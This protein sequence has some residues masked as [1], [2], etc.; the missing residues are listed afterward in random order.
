MDG[1]GNFVVV[2]NANDGS[3]DGVFATV[4]DRNGNITVSEFRVNDLITDRQAVVDVKMN[5]NGDFAIIWDNLTTTSVAGVYTKRYQLDGSALGTEVFVSD[6]G[7]KQY[8]MGI[9]MS[10]TG[11]FAI[12]MYRQI[13]QTDEIDV[14]GQRFD[15]QGNLLG[16]P[17]L[18]NSY[19]TGTQIGN[20]IAMDA[21]GNFVIS[22][23]SWNQD[24]EG[25]GIYAQRY[26]TDGSKLGGEFLVNTTTTNSQEFARVAMAGDG[27]FVITWEHNV[28]FVLPTL[29]PVIQAR[30]YN[31]NG[32]PLGA[33][34]RISATTDKLKSQP[35]V[36]ADVCGNFIIG[37]SSFD[38]SATNGVAIARR[39]LAENP[40]T[41]PCLINSQ[42][43]ANLSGDTYSWQYY[44]ITVP[45]G[46]SILDIQQWGPVTGDADLYVKYGALPTFTEWDY[47]P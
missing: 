11:L 31:T 33:E 46:Q 29:L 10:Q 4:Y 39:Y 7:D 42:T 28:E 16:V 18:V 41:G 47:R 27:S 14:W 45:A 22:W 44:K 5:R 25:W 40:S 12:T 21:V 3:D 32:V 23:E 6:G 19:L 43:V 24:G 36:G 17:F 30:Q 8:A 35:T 37:W 20:D 26:A 34:F 9:A 13:P 38:I 15:A 2:K 1:Q